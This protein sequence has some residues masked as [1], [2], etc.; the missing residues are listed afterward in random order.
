M[1]YDTR[2]KHN[3]ITIF[4]VLKNGWMDG[5]FHREREFWGVGFWFP[6]A[7]IQH[8]IFIISIIKT[9]NGNSQFWV[10]LSVTHMFVNIFVS[11]RFPGS[12][13]QAKNKI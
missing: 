11:W 7:M 13:L 3:T 4:L 5:S 1:C 9:R 6:L 8:S 2:T 10:W 12:I